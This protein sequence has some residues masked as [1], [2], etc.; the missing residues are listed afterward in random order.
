M[1]DAFCE[2]KNTT[3]S[4]EKLSQFNILVYYIPKTWMEWLNQRASPVQS[5]SALFGSNEL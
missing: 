4:S 3:E 5:Q 2:K 1:V